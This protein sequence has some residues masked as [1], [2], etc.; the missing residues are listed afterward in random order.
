MVLTSLK[1]D[2]LSRLYPDLLFAL[3]GEAFSYKGL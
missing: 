1:I 2:G 3:K